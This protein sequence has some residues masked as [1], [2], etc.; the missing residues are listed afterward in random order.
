MGGGVVGLEEVTRITSTSIQ[1]KN[2]HLTPSL[3]KTCKKDV[4][5]VNRTGSYGGVEGVGCG[6]GVKSSAELL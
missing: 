5:S 6:W 4:H 2:C 3:K 1:T